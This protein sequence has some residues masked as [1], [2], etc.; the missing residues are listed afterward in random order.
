[1]IKLLD[2]FRQPD[3]DIAEVAEL[4]SRDPAL[5]AEVLK[6]CNS[7]AITGEHPVADMFE[8]ISRLGFYEVY[9]LVGMISGSRVM[10]LQSAKAVVLVERLSRHSTMTATAA[11]I[12]AKRVGE[13]MVAGFTAGLLHDIGK[14]VFASAEG[15]NYS[16]LLKQAEAR[17]ETNSQAEK[18][19]FGFN[20]SEVGARLLNRWTVPQEIVNAVF[21]HDNLGAAGT[22][23]RLAAT[24]GLASAIANGDAKDPDKLSPRAAKAAAILKLDADAIGNIISELLREMA[25]RKG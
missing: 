20:H 2:A 11:A 24:V 7:A 22:S 13:S 19:Y 8:A 23:V 21:F 10:A 4:I 18:Q 17:G 3:P 5:S 25:A 15:D 12:I 16:S 9:C 14:I 1:M 6:R